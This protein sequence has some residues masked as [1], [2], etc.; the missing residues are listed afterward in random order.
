MAD[1][2]DP[3]ALGIKVPDTMASIGQVMSAANAAQNLKTNQF[4]LGVAQDTRAATVAK[5]NADAS[6]A[7]SGASLAAQTLPMKVEQ[8]SQ[9]TQQSQIATHTQQF[10]LD[11]NQTGVG[12]QILGGL[13]ADPDVQAAATATP[14]QMTDAA[15]KTVSAVRSA[16]DRMV[17]MGIPAEK[18]DVITAPFL[19]VAAH[20]PSGLAGALKPVIV[21]GQAPGT[22][23]ATVTPAT[24]AI[25]TG[26]RTD[27]LN[28]G[29]NP[30]APPPGPAPLA[31]V[32]NEVPVTQPTFNAATQAPSIVGP[33]PRPGMQVPP[34]VQAS[35]DGDALRIVQDERAKATNPADIVALDREI[36]RLTP[37]AAMPGTVAPAPIQTAPRLGQAENV[38][39]TVGAANSDYADTVKNAATAAQDVGVLQKIKAL[40]PGAITGVGADRRAFLDGIAGLIGWQGNSADLAKTNTDELI[41]NSNML[42]LGGNTDAARTLLLAANPN[43]HMTKDA[44]IDAANQV[45]AQRKLALAK[46][47][48]LTPIKSLG[49]ENAYMGALAKW[50][51]NADP[52]ALQVP[53]MAPADIAKMKAGMSPQ[54]QAEFSQ[55]MRNLHAMGVNG[56]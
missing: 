26:Q 11:S 52:R 47:Q 10:A 27:V 48:F 51:A 12:H 9:Q 5:A 39:G 24:A 3:V 37:R 17:D 56:G 4:N 18:A 16:R 22:Q 30:F 38:A 35:R 53:N 34:A 55:K 41:K 40:A 21:G 29:A 28:T 13:A 42:G 20:N 1:F 44:I 19:M 2:A 49:D 15:K 32:P 36:Q 7:T 43:S 14:E 23:S 50:N 6:S 54:E 31:S 45:I 33:Q 8:Q 25:N 46:Q